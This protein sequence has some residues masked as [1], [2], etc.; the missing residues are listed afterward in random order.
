MTVEAKE[1][2]CYVTSIKP[3]CDQVDEIVGKAKTGSKYHFIKF[4]LTIVVGHAVQGY[5]NDYGYRFE[6]MDQDAVIYK[7][8]SRLYPIA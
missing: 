7:I 3:F 8:L 4:K 6:Y 5:N 1:L 2:Y